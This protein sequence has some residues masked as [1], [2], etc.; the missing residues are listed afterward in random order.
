[1]PNWV[2]VPLA[3]A[4][5]TKI[6][7]VTERGA[8]FAA[9]ILAE[10]APRLGRIISN[11]LETDPE[12]GLSLRQYRMLERLTE[13]PHR[14]G[15]LATISGIAQPTASAAITSL[16]A[17]ELVDRYPDPADRRAT[18][19]AINDAGRNVLAI[20]KDRV[21]ERLELV[22]ADMTSADAEALAAVQPVLIAGMDRLRD[23]LRAR[24]RQQQRR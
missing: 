19:I 10:L 20:A 18:L 6:R 22:T 17:R 2:S 1:M 5:P 15:E 4:G 3:H 7:A 16:E 23:E 21:L 8:R 24:A 14:T 9:L 12:I 13:R 11:A